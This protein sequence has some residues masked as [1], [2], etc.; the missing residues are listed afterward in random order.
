MFIGKGAYRPVSPKDV[1]VDEDHLEL[2]T[3]TVISVVLILAIF[4]LAATRSRLLTRIHVQR[5]PSSV[6]ARR[7]QPG[8]PVPFQATG[9]RLLSYHR[10]GDCQQENTQPE[11]ERPAVRSPV[12]L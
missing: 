5:P 8:N 10:E 12:L 6:M 9:F 1:L 11:R 3:A 2:P 4:A 7:L